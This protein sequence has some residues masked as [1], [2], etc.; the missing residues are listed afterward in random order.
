MI[1]LNSEVTSYPF[2]LDIAKM[3]LLAYEEINQ[4]QFTPV[5]QEII[6]VNW[7]D[8]KCAPYNW[9]MTTKNLAVISPLKWRCWQ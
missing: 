7:R 6:G 9:N 8:M 4:R 3:Y 2:T 5:N 1:T